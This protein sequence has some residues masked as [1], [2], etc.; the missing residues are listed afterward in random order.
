[1]TLYQV[2]VHHNTTA[3]FMPFRPQDELT[4]VFMFAR[5]L[6][7]ETTAEQ[8]ADWT[9]HTFNMDLEVLENDFATPGAEVAFP[10]ACVYRLLRLRSLST[11]DVV[12]ITV[13]GRTTWLAC[14]P[15]GWRRIETPAGLPGRPSTAAKVHEHLRPDDGA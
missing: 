2:A 14:E 4:L 3:R 8:I 1:M 11:G 12:A 6:P 7:D 10:L 9:F 5:D 13:D 15:A